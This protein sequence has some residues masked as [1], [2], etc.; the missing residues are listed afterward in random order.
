MKISQLS[1][2][3][4]LDVL[5]EITPFLCSIIEDD[6]LRDAL[7]K[8]VKLEADAS[9]TEIYAEA[10]RKLGK[11][12]P[13]VTKTHRDDVYG[14]VAAVNG[15]NPDE[16]AKQNIIKTAGDIRDIIN[17]KEFKDFFSSLRNTDGN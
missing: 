2:D 5:C 8:K 11:I 7:R 9:V 14:I 13:I 1:T 6:N 12:I 10:I 15:K 3:E 16:I 17:D 4:G